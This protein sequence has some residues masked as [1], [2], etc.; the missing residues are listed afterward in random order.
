MGLPQGCFRWLVNMWKP[1]K[2]LLKERMLNVAMGAVLLYI[3][4]GRRG[5]VNWWWSF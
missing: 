4:R 5:V 1:G 2:Y 3:T